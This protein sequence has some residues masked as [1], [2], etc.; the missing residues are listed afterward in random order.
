MNTPK[1]RFNNL[2]YEVVEIVNRTIRIRRGDD[3]LCVLVDRV[4][5]CNAEARAL[6]KRE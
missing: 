6:L 3:E 1:V 2:T 5:P 4:R